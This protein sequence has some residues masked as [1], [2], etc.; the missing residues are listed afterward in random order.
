MRNAQ[1]LDLYL[2]SKDCM[3][4]VEHKWFGDILAHIKDYTYFNSGWLVVMETSDGNPILAEISWLRTVPRK[5]GTPAKP[6]RVHQ[7]G[8]KPWLSKFEYVDYDPKLI[9]PGV[10]V[11][12]RDKKI[13]T[14]EHI[15]HFN[16][17]EHVIN[18]VNGACAFL[19]SG[20]ANGPGMPHGHDTMKIIVEKKIDKPVHDRYNGYEVGKWHFWQGNTDVPPVDGDVKVEYWMR[21]YKWTYREIV[22]AN[23]L[24]WYWDDEFKNNDIIA[25]KIV[26]D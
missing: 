2:L 24:R 16:D 18:F 13:R 8:T 1:K 7:S 26:S 9:A 3:Y 10:R 15:E 12:C 6:K 17:G 22:T 20:M 5:Q 25:F 14:V 4:L 23:V 19:P 11:K 21:G